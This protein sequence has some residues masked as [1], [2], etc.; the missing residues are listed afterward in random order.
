MSNCPSCKEEIEYLFHYKIKTTKSILRTGNDNPIPEGEVYRD[1]FTCPV[2]ATILAY[3]VVR[4]M[5]LLMG[6]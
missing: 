2:C 1:E 5:D 4:A 3:D 6:R